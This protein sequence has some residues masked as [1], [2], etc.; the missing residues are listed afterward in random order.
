GGRADPA[1]R[2]RHDR[3]RYPP[4]VAAPAGPGGD[5]PGRVAVPYGVGAAGYRLCVRLSLVPY[6][7]GICFALIVAV[8]VHEFRRG[9]RPEVARAPVARRMA[10]GALAGGVFG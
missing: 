4:A 8:R 7:A 1:V 9:A 6:G 5:E 10:V 2:G 3:R